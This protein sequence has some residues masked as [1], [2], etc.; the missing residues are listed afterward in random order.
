LI[1]AKPGDQPRSD[2]HDPAYS[3]KDSTCAVVGAC[4]L[5]EGIGAGKLIDECLHLVAGPFLEQAIEN[6]SDGRSAHWQICQARS[7]GGPH[8]AHPEDLRDE[9]DQKLSGSWTPV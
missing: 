3:R 7:T 4:G 5:G 9:C 6:N 8:F 1:H 2:S